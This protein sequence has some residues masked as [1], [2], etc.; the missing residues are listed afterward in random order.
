MANPNLEDEDVTDQEDTEV[1]AP[2]SP[3]ENTPTEESSVD[4]AMLASLAAQAQQPVPA[5]LASPGAP[6][7]VQNIKNQVGQS[8]LPADLSDEALKQAQANRQNSLLTSLL[9]KAGED[10]RVA[11]AKMHGTDLKPNYDVADTLQ[12]AAN[13]PVQ[14]I[15]ERNANIQESQKLESGALDLNNLKDLNDKGSTVSQAARDLASQILNKPVPED[16]NAQ[17]LFKL[18]PLLKTRLGSIN[19]MQQGKVLENGNLSVFD[20]AQ[21]IYKD[22]GLKASQELMQARDPLTGEVKLLSR[23]TGQTTGTLGAPTALQK[24]DANGN[25]VAATDANG[26]PV[27]PSGSDI[28]NSLN[29]KQRD[30]YDKARTALIKDPAVANARKALLSSDTAQTLL[31]QNVPGSAGAVQHA[32]ARMFSNGGKLSNQEI[33][34]FGGSHALL[35]R[36]NQIIETSKS[37]KITDD[38][39]KYLGQVLNIVKRENQAALDNSTKFYRSGFANQ[40]GLKPQMVD[41]LVAHDLSTAPDNQQVGAPVLSKQ[42]GSP[43]VPTTNQVSTPGTVKMRAPDGS[44]RAVPADKVQAALAK[45]GQLAE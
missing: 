35:D 44:I 6:S 8:G 39:R 1:Q 7:I 25:P 40:T 13:L 34:Q 10:F 4:P 26:N 28:Y 2:A 29:S 24:T 16:M 45:G 23:R 12:A 43:K 33:Q 37:G 42:Q 32:L 27:Q 5:P 3:D 38:N 31:Q 36:L 15:K 9:S 14:D 21:G 41:Q 19:K 20:P 18:M 22:T 30:A 11:G 17:T